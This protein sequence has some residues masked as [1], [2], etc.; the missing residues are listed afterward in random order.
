MTLAVNT[1]TFI[2]EFSAQGSIGKK[3][4]DPSFNIH[5]AV[6]LC[7]AGLIT[8]GIETIQASP[9]MQGQGLQHITPFMKGHLPQIRIAY[10]PGIGSD[11]TKIKTRCTC[12]GYRFTVHRIK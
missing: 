8:D 6:G 12:P 1:E 9:Q 2:G 5:P 10:L 4:A 7:C 11:R 3:V